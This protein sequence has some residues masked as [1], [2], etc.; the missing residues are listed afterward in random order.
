[1]WALALRSTS[2]H[3]LAG[4]TDGAMLLRKAAR[5]SWSRYSRRS[6]SENLD[7]ADADGWV[8]PLRKGGEAGRRKKRKEKK[9][10]EVS[11]GLLIE[12][13]RLLI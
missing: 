4:N 8:L 10:N 3:S 2:A 7:H 13:V 5:T 1:M 11:I 6:F 12:R 9:A